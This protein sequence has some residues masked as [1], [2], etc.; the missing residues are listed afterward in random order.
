ML[1]KVLLVLVLV[2]GCL[3]NFSGVEAANWQWVVSSSKI[4][5]TIDLDSISK[6]DGIYTVWARFKNADYVDK[7]VN[8]QRVDYTA[9]QLQYK[10]QGNGYLICQA[11]SI[12]YHDE[13]DIGEWTSSRWESV[14]PS[15]F[16]DSILKRVLAERAAADKKEEEQLNKQQQEQAAAQAAKEKQE[17]A[18]SKRRNNEQA[19]ANVIGILGGILG[20]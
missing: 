13:E 5:V 7:Y 11:R 6:S 12:A 10:K 17:K 16:G 9:D 8:H 18:E 4:T 15:T 20:R 1:R 19:A 14:I 2:V 3:G